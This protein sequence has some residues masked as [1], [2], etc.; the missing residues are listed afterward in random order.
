MIT[1]GY[2]IRLGT[3]DHRSSRTPGYQIHLPDGMKTLP[4]LFREAGYETFNASKD[5]FNF[6]YDR[7]RLYSLGNE[8][9]TMT[10]AKNWKGPSGGGHWRE[11]PAGKPFYGQV[12]ISGGK[13]IRGLEAF[14]R[15]AGRTPVT[16]EQVRV[17]AQY[18]DIPQVRAHIAL[19]YNTI[20]RTDIEVGQ[21]IEELKADGLWGSTVL[22]LYA[23]HGADLPR[24]KEFVYHEGLHSP[25]IIAAPGVR[26]PAVPGTHR[27][28]LVSLMDV[29]ATSLALAGIA[30][31]ESMD[32]RNVFDPGYHR[33]YVFSSQDRMSNMLDRVRSVMG[34]AFHYIRN[35]MTDRPLMNWGHREMIALA[36]PEK[37]SFLTIRAMAAAGKLTP[38]QAAPY[39]DR[40]VEELYHLASDPDEVANLADD[41]RYRKQLDVMRRALEQWLDETGDRGQFARPAGAMK[42]I[43]DRYPKAW[44]RSPEFEP[45]TTVIP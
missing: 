40:V 14:L 35:F 18:P 33:E 31:P 10:S 39:G 37:S 12:M 2:P 44:L 1:G 41:P 30:V 28:D 4:E 42:E 8:N 9:V 43:T 23:D 36:A 32:S 19:H 5:D 27:D 45:D 22:V 25:L 21:L 16:P 11:V 38:A 6:V 26:T 34:N 7:T 13:T 29:T 17:P 3:H 20:Q 24:S 15:S